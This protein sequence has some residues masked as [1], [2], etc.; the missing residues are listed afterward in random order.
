MIIPLV[1]IQWVDF[2]TCRVCGTVTSHQCLPVDE[3]YYCGHKCNI[4]GLVTMQLR[5]AKEIERAGK[6]EPAGRRAGL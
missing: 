2:M 1:N 4:C 3:C 5:P 6:A